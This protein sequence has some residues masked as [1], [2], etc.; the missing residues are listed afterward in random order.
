LTATPA[1]ACTAVLAAAS[2]S[3]LAANPVD[4]T[5][6]NNAVNC[7]G[8]MK[9]P[10]VEAAAEPGSPLAGLIDLRLT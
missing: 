4:C 3:R 1:L 8:T 2:N 6:P 7:P 9:S 5:D 10:M